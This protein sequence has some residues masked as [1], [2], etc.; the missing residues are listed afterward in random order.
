MNF[1]FA[2]YNY[3]VKNLEQS[4]K[5]YEEALGL[6]EVR[7]KEAEDGSFILVYL[8]DGKTG[9]QLELT[10]LRDWEKDHYDLGDNEIHLAFT[11]DN[12]EA[13]HKSM[14]KWA[15]SAMKIRKWEFILLTIL[16]DIG[17]RLYRRNRKLKVRFK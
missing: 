1:Q 15:V 11:T 13:A 4:M 5:F 3:N 12:M 14:K 17:W 8:G 10:W 2:H 16:M 6:K 9:F 7:R